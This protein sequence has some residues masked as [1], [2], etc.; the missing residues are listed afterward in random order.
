M[1]AKPCDTGWTSSHVIR[2]L[3]GVPM[4]KNGPDPG[5][6]GTSRWPFVGKVPGAHGCSLPAAC[7]PACGLSL[8]RALGALAPNSG[9]GAQKQGR[10]EGPHDPARRRSGSEAQ[11]EDEACSQRPGQKRGLDPPSV[12]LTGRGGD[13]GLFQKEKQRPSLQPELRQVHTRVVLTSL[14]LPSPPPTGPSLSHSRRPLTRSLRPDAGKW[15][16]CPLQALSFLEV[17]N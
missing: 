13:R 2:A 14:S 4:D 16:V 10:C 15:R 7:P 17:K 3:P 12:W 6:R 11:E 8:G 1:I 5:A 9:W